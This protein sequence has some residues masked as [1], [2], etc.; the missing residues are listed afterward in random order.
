MALTKSFYI[1][2][3]KEVDVVTVG[4]D[5]RGF[6]REARLEEGF[7]VIGCRLPGAVLVLLPTEGKGL[8]EAREGI[9]KLFQT[10]S[11]GGLRHLLPPSLTIPIEQGKMHF[12][13]WQEI[14]LV[15]HELSG[16]RREVVVSL[17]QRQAEGQQE[18]GG[19]KR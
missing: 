19:R 13:P 11:I 4:H 1:G 3:T 16:R 7:A 14:Y 15:D 17:Y 10:E 12:E 2:T 18:G 6:I 5:V 9:R 8:A